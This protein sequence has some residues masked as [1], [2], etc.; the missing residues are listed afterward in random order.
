M[1]IKEHKR[2]RR[3]GLTVDERHLLHSIHIAQAKMKEA[4]YILN[5]PQTP[6]HKNL[7][8]MGYIK[9]LYDL[10]GHNPQWSITDDANEVLNE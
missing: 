3:R 4:A 6:L 1:A 5:I 7:V 2:R 9:T 10:H 8:N